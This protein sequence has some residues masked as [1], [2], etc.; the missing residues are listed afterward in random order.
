M[1]IPQLCLVIVKDLLLKRE[2]ETCGFLLPLYDLEKAQLVIDPQHKGEKGMCLLSK[3]STM[4]WHTHPY[5]SKAYLGSEDVLAVIKKHKNN[6]GY[7][8]I[9]VI[10]TCWGVWELSGEKQ[11]LTKEQIS[12]VKEVVNEGMKKVYF[13][14]EKGRGN[15][16]L[17]LLKLLMVK[18]K[19]ILENVNENLNCNL[20]IGFTPW[21]G[22][23]EGYKMKFV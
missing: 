4:I 20:K 18:T 16:N 2:K 11:E 3:Y 19:E 17:D 14:S 13:S 23:K 5:V 9:S 21:E 12:F 10:F 1:I 7:P 6:M 8:K 22:L 15:L